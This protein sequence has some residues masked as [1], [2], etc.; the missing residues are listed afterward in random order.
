MKLHHSKILLTVL[1]LAALTGF[2]S[3]AP[4]SQ[5]KERGKIVLD[6]TLAPT[7][8]APPNITASASI[9]ID[10]KKFHQPGVATLTLT[11]TGL[12]A[13]DYGIDALLN[14]GTDPVHLGAFTVEPPAVVDPVPPAP[15]T[16]I[17][18]GSIDATLIA[19]LSITDALAAVILQGDAVVTSID[20]Q[21]LANVRI[22]GDAPVVSVSK[23]KGPKVKAPFGHVISQSTFK[24]GVEK[25]RHFL[26][27]GHGAPA[28]TELT[29]NVDGVAVGTV[30]ST[31]KGKVMFHQLPAEVVLRDVK[32]VTLTDGGG[33][34]V[35]KAEF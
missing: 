9:T 35:M 30:T 18:D 29:V 23:G 14:G 16:L 20:W 24:A 6:V 13:G 33:A 32:L 31:A 17:L 7:D 19:S 8:V 11:S 2:A 4:K 22:T 25:K 1:A 21:Y 15:V 5:V 3:A 10:K 26:W 34:V 27:V 28:D 12:P